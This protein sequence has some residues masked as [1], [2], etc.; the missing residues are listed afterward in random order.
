MKYKKSLIAFLLTVV[1][2]TVGCSNK[3]EVEYEVL[4][5]DKLPREFQNELLNFK[6]SGFSIQS[7]ERYTYVF[8]R[9]EHLE[10][11]YIST[12]LSIYKR[13]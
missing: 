10:D 11:E 12:D 9:A 2:L 6:R 5:F 7:D 13:G 8:Y 1:L 3:R 4:N